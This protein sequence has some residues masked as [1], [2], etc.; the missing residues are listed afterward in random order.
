MS[1]LGLPEPH[2]GHLS[3][4]AVQTALQ[5]RRCCRNRGWLEREVGEAGRATAAHPP[6]ALAHV[7][8]RC[9][10]ARSGGTMSADN[11]GQSRGWPGAA[12]D[13]AGGGVGSVMRAVSRRVGSMRTRRSTMAAALKLRLVRTFAAGQR[14]TEKCRER[15][16]HPQT[17]TICLRSSS[18]HLVE[19]VGVSAIGQLLPVDLGR[20]SG[21]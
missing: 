16:C 3:A 18:G 20:P 11:W 15:T 5:L 7:S 8:D 6:R 1:R 13:G 14:L 12:G 17:A 21:P 9:R 19:V 10:A 4:A 2:S